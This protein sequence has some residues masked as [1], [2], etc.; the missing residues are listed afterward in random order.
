[1][2]V[3]CN[4][5]NIGNTEESYT[6]ILQNK[7]GNYRYK[8]KPVQT[9]AKKKTNEPCAS[10]EEQEVAIPSWMKVA[11]EGSPDLK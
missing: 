2:N 1:M 10:S 3:T 9:K 8:L 5:L 6:T 7:I 11:L 4:A